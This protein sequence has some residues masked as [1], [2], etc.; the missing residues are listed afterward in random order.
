MKMN[1]NVSYTTVTAMQLPHRWD[2][3]LEKTYQTTNP[4]RIANALRVWSTGIM[5]TREEQVI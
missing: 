4:G 2:L 1:C 5:P 3:K